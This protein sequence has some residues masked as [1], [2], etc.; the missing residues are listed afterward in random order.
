M[1]TYTVGGSVSGLAGTGLTL[2]SGG[3]TLAVS[4]NGAF[5]FSAGL[6]SGTAYAVTVATQP[7]NPGQVCTMT[8]GSGTIAA[9]NIANL[10]VLC[11]TTPL[12]MTSSSP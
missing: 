8:N 5:E 11:V 12:T 9:A 1:P 3:V 6:A 7:I 4:S 10:S 2:S